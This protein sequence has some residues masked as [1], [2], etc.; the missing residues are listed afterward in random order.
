MPGAPAA[1][2]GGQQPEALVQDLLGV[3]YAALDA[4]AKKVALHIL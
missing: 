1:P 3:S 4:P 2:G